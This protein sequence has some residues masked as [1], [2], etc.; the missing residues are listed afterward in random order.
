M[1]NHRKYEKQ[2]YA[3][4]VEQRFVLRS[5][6]YTAFLIFIGV[7]EPRLANYTFVA[8]ILLD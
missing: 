5:S 7:Q 2:E 6:L 4:L 1:T 3:R 8:S